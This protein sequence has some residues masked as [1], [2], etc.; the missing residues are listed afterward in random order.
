MSRDIYLDNPSTSGKIYVTSMLT[1]GSTIKLYV[2][3]I[4]DTE[5][6]WVELSSANPIVP[7]T[8]SFTENQFDIGEVAEFIGIRVKLVVRG[9]RTN[10][11]VIRDIRGVLLA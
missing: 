8:S 3:Y 9:P 7:G 11:P 4:N 2:K 6:N 5:S 1:T 10:P